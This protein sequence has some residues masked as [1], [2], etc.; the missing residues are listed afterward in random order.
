MMEN[1][2]KYIYQDFNNS[3][4]HSDELIFVAINKKN[5]K[6]EI[7]LYVGIFFIIIIVLLFSPFCRR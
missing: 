6:R 2:I 1:F 4:D 5:C 7:I 3:Y